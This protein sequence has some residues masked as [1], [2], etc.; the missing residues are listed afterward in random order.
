MMRC[1]IFLV[2]LVES[3]NP[4][5]LGNTITFNGMTK[6]K[7]EPQILVGFGVQVFILFWFFL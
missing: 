3:R 5:V 4:R 2:L 1:E 7:N 6:V